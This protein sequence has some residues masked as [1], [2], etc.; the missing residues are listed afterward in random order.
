MF[1]SDFH[2]GRFHAAMDWAF[3]LQPAAD[4]TGAN[5]LVSHH[6]TSV[7]SAG[8]DWG[9]QVNGRGVYTKQN[10][11]GALV[12]CP[13][14]AYCHDFLTTSLRLPTT[15]H[16]FLRLPAGSCSCLDPLNILRSNQTPAASLR[17][18]L[19]PTHLTLLRVRM[20]TCTHA[21]PH[22]RP[23]RTNSKHGK[24]MRRMGRPC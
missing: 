3:G 7:S 4:Y 15:S 12:L 10:G 14:Y 11:G 19:S 23:R 13:W 8:I 20:H 2:A 21:L 5:A 24:R 9:S 17:P 16:D 6:V 22:H 18:P 1:I